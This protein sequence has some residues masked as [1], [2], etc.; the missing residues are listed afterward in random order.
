ME[1]PVDIADVAHL[2]ATQDSDV[3]REMVGLP[4]GLAG[5]RPLQQRA[6]VLREWH[7]L[8]YREVAAELGV[9]DST[10]ETLIVRGR[11]GLAQQ[12]R[13]KERGTGSRGR[14]GFSMPSWLSL[15]GLLG[16]GTVLKGVASAA[17]V[18]VVALTAHHALPVAAPAAATPVRAAS[19]LPD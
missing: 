2:A 7:G 6:L 9:S 11:R 3:R 5:M 1:Y 4:E 13:G 10:A 15:K 18:V 12:L 16:G 8:S 14:F 17:S 19:S